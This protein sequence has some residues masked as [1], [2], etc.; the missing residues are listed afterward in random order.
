MLES[1]QLLLAGRVLQACRFLNFQ[2]VKLE[3]H[4]WSIWTLQFELK[5][6]HFVRL[7]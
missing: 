2:K 5:H 7:R 1:S 4:R 3:F 6:Q